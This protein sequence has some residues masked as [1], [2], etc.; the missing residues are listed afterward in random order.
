MKT[1]AHTQ[2]GVASRQ[3]EVARL[4]AF[5]TAVLLMGFPGLKAAVENPAPQ[6]VNIVLGTSG[7]ALPRGGAKS[8]PKSHAARRPVKKKAT[9]ATITLLET[10]IWAARAMLWGPL[11][12]IGAA[13]VTRGVALLQGWRMAW[14]EE[15]DGMALRETAVRG[16]GGGSQTGPDSG[17]A[18]L[19]GVS[20]TAPE[21]VEPRT[22]LPGRE[23]TEITL[24]LVSAK[25]TSGKSVP[26]GQ[27]FRGWDEQQFATLKKVF[28]RHPATSHAAGRHAAF[29]SVL[30]EL[31]SQEREADLRTAR[32]RVPAPSTRP[33][34]RLRPG[35]RMPPPQ[36]PKR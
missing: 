13:L 25:E 1:F 14:R 6:A 17:A 3:R 32:A 22:V 28:E 24:P 4:S 23:L 35:R 11:L 15:N 16:A 12:L 26:Q 19:P 36:S 9:A 7:S 8:G 33:P 18:A 27:D 5:A 34:V 21:Q 10:V 31:S 2:K 29:E 20:A 30:K